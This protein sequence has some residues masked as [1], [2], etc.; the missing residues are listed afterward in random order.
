MSTV[1]IEAREGSPVTTTSS[2]ITRIMSY[3]LQDP[4]GSKRLGKEERPFAAYRAGAP[5]ER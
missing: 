2:R 3:I 1:Y 5:S 4:D